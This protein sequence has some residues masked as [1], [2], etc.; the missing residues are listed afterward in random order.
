MKS[1]EG[2]DF[3]LISPTQRTPFIRDAQR[4]E[5]STKMSVDKRGPSSSANNTVD[6]TILAAV[7]VIALVWNALRCPALLCFNKFN[8]VQYLTLLCSF[9]LSSILLCSVSASIQSTAGLFLCGSR[10]PDSAAQQPRLIAVDSLLTGLLLSWKKDYV[11]SWLFSFYL[12]F[13]PHTRC[14]VGLELVTGARGCI[15]HEKEPLA[16][17]AK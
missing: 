10:R 11:C 8:L 3:K 9:L 7:V 13:K 17:A 4:A 14:R 12:Y 6:K 1:A 15:I 16:A 2:A 5:T